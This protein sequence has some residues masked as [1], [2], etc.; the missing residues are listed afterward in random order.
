MGCNGFEDE[1][2]PTYEPPRPPGVLP[3]NQ[4]RSDHAYAIYAQAVPTVAPDALV[5]CQSYALGLPQSVAMCKRPLLDHAG[6]PNVQ[7]TVPSLTSSTFE[8]ELM[9]IC[10]TWVLAVRAWPANS[11]Q[12]PVVAE[13]A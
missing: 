9:R 6:K 3:G 1:L 4:S 10:H 13:V 5:H 2:K 8:S 7:M 12:Q 11:V